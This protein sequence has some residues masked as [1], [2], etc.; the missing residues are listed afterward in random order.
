MFWKDHVQKLGSCKL[1]SCKC[2]TGNRFL[3]FSIECSTCKVAESAWNRLSIQCGLNG[4]SCKSTD[5]FISLLKVH[6][7]TWNFI[8][9]LNS[10]FALCT[11]AL[12]SSGATPGPAETTFLRI[13]TVWHIACEIVRQKHQ[14]LSFFCRANQLLI[15][16][17]LCQRR[18]R[19]EGLLIS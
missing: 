11:E 18:I 1:L 8:K 19:T 4:M 3:H 12:V 10:T 13:C 16:I 9:W 15:P 17:L 2:H 7:V 6:W 5:F 14:I